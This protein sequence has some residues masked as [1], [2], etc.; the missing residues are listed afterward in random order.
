MTTTTEKEAVDKLREAAKFILKQEVNNLQLVP[1]AALKLLRLTQDSNTQ[2]SDLAK[3]IETEPALAAKVLRNVNSAAYCLPH[4]IASIKRAVNFLGFSAVRRS[5]LDLL[6]YNK[7]INHQLKR[8][9]NL[10]FFWQHCLFVAALSK[11]IADVLKHPEPDLVYTA[12]LLH[13]I[14]K[15]VLET[16]SRLTYSDFL[17][18]IKPQYQITPENEQRFFGLTHSQIGYLFCLEWQLPNAITA[19]VCY[20]HDSF[21]IAEQYQGFRLETA[22]VAFAD[23]VAWMQGIGSVMEFCHPALDK[24]VHEMIEVDKLDLADLLQK[25]DQDM[26]LTQEFYGIQFPSPAQLRASL[27]KTSLNLTRL[28][29]DLENAASPLT[30]A[31]SGKLIIPH[32]GLYP[33]DF[34]P[35]TLEAIQQEYNYNRVILLQINPQDRSFFAAFSWPEM[36][37]PEL[38]VF[39]IKIDKI[40]GGLLQCLRKKTGMLIKSE[41]KIYQSFFDLLGCK[42]FIAVPVIQEGKLM[43][44]IYADNYHSNTALY[45]YQAKEIMP[46]ADELGLALHKAK[47]F[48]VEKHKAQLDPLTQL[49][50]KGKIQE[51]LTGLFNQPEVYR[52][53]MAI[54][55]ID[56]DR[57][58]RLNDNCGHQ[59]G[60]DALKL[61][62][63]TI[64]SLTR[65]SDFVGRYGGEEFIFV[66]CKAGEKGALQYAERIRKE[67]ER[68]GEL[69]KPRFKNQTITASIGLALYHPAYSHFNEMIE[70][71]DQA[72]YLAKELGRNRVVMAPE[73]PKNPLKQSC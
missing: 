2:L 5:A 27:V 69:I 22:I 25:V 70:A 41:L 6:F 28:N 71:A 13:D 29:P 67:I 43:G 21:N 40:T 42:E 7:L 60:D 51:Y 32:R 49:Y 52:H 26:Q 23:Y 33:K 59:A 24:N 58:K 48:R 35:K 64:K 57:F 62:A 18:S 38:K 46:L 8:E 30:P 10:L 4:K 20:H 39:N 45:E 50:N 9:F 37:L 73:K 12:G 3:I 44:L 1:S 61:I 66:L 47:Q 54:G 19:V 11:R 15:I 36:L 56:I 53:E 16:A 72:M 55:F 31:F 68:Q 14:G 65:P 17:Q 63:E 34:V